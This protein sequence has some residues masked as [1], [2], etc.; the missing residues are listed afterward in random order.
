MTIAPSRYRQMQ[1]TWQA[2]GGWAVAPAG[3]DLASGVLA[4]VEAASGQEGPIRARP[5]PT[6]RL[7]LA[8]GRKLAASVGLAAV[9]GYVVGLAAR[10]G[11]DRSVCHRRRP[12]TG[13]RR[14]LPGHPHGRFTRRTGRP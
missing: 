2:L 11:T 5:V 6:A 10:P 1:E 9:L 7:G 12:A 14:A 8:D 13:R 3:L 4:E